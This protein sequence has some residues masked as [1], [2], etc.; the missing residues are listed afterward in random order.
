MAGT[1]RTRGWVSCLSSGWRHIGQSVLG[2]HAQS[3]RERLTVFGARRVRGLGCLLTVRDKPWSQ[4][5]LQSSQPG[6][7]GFPVGLAAGI[8]YIA[9]FGT[10]P[11]DFPHTM[12]IRPVDAKSRLSCRSRHGRHSRC[13]VDE[14]QPSM[15]GVTHLMDSVPGTGCAD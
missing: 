15:G 1:Q 4:G 2:L 13:I 11:F 5:S 9:R 7:W 8:G 12:E 6:V 14:L 10:P 3:G